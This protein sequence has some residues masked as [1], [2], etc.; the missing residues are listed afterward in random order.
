MRIFVI[1]VL[2]TCILISDESSGQDDSLQL[3]T[4]TSGSEIQ[5]FEPSDRGERI[6]TGQ[7]MF[8]DDG[9]LPIMQTSVFE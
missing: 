5:N 2:F 1:L 7:R 4:D 3:E 8:S 9:D 6:G